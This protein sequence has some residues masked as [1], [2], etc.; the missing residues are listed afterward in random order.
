MKI[1][2]EIAKANVVN[3]N[4]RL[5]TKEAL[6]NAVN[7]Y[8]SKDSP[9]YLYARPYKETPGWDREVDRKMEDI[10]GVC[11]D[12][13]FDN[14]NNTIV[15]EFRLID[16]NKGKEYQE[17]IRS[18]FRQR[19]VANYITEG[20]KE[21]EEG[22]SVVRNCKIIHFDLTPESSWSKYLD[23]FSMID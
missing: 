20:Y 7:N 13:K 4:R 22:Y 15:A 9:C 17:L 14:N 1:K 2:A 5:Y 10:I 21:S 19:I 12:L 6:I 18:G 11:E 3:I 23:D 8:N 16:S